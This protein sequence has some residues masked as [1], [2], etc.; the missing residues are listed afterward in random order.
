MEV[1]PSHPLNH[2][3]VAKTTD[4]GLLVFQDFEIKNVKLCDTGE[5]GNYSFDF[6]ALFKEAEVLA[7]DRIDSSEGINVYHFTVDRHEYND[8]IG[9]FDVYCSHIKIYWNY[10]E[11]DSWFVR[12]N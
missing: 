11:K 10:F 9:E 1:L 3:E 4:S 8:V 2:L 7:V 5:I 6:H 12:W